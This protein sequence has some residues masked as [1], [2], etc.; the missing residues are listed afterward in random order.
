VPIT[1]ASDAHE[2]PTVAHRS[3]D[4]RAMVAAAGYTEVTA[5]SARRRRAVP[6]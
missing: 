2:L 1:T 6:V 5:F 4:V 3:D